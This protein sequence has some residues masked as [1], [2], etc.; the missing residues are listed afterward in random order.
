[1]HSKTIAVSIILTVHIHSASLQLEE[2]N[3]LLFQNIDHLKE[4]FVVVK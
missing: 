1:M 2:G 3:I 4:N